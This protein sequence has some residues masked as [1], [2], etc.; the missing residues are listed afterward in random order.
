MSIKFIILIVNMFFYLVGIAVLIIVKIK[1]L[2]WGFP[3]SNFSNITDYENS[4]WL[5]R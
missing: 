3:K 5:P 4:I 2:F 1:Y